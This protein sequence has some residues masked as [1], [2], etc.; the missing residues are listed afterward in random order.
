[1]DGAAA[2]A[3]G[4]YSWSYQ[5]DQIDLDTALDGIAEVFNSYADRFIENE[6]LA[7]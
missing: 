7:C 3:I 2:E 4:N 6:G 1:M 5:L